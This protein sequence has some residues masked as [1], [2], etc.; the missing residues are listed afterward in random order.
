VY[1][2]SRDHL[3]GPLLVKNLILVPPLEELPIASLKL[4][5]LPLVSANTQL[6]HML[7]IFQTGKCHM[8]AVVDEND[9]WSPIGIISLEDVI[10]ELIQ[11]EIEDEK[12]SLIRLSNDAANSRVS[13]QDGGMVKLNFDDDSAEED[14]E[15][16]SNLL[17]K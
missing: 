9:N 5:R 14:T 1:R 2:D 16:T 11:E 12:D 8:A 15:V 3:V 17:D 6:Y 13:V 7:N 4:T 10:E